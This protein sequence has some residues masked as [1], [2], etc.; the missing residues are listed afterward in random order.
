MNEDF[1]KAYIDTLLNEVSELHKLRLLDKTKLSFMEK[2][3]ETL[4]EELK[5]YTDKPETVEIPEIPQ[6]TNS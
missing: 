2:H 5:K 4:N 3:V 1:I 6:E